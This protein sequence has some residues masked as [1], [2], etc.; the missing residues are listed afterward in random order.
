VPT[1]KTTTRKEPVRP[2]S[3]IGVKEL[4]EHL[5]TDPRT[6]RGFLRRQ[7]QSVGRGTRYRWGSLKDPAVAKLAAAWK[8]Q[9]ETD[10]AS[11]Q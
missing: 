6:L 10:T 4:A 5:G 2:T 9:A 1:T 7:D 8:A 11:A 3:E